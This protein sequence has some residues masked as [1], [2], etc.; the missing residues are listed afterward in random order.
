MPDARVKISSI[1]ANVKRMSIPD[2]SVDI[3]S[4]PDARINM[5][6]VFQMPGGGVRGGEGVCTLEYDQSAK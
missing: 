6:L 3:C 4:I 1:P 2:A 5:Y